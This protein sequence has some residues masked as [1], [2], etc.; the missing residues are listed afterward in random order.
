MDYRLPDTANLSFDTDLHLQAR[1][2]T[3]PE[4][5]MVR[6]T[7]DVLD[8]IFYRDISLFE[9]EVT[10]RVMG[11]FS[12]QT[13][14]YEAGLFDQIPALE[15]VQ[16]DLALRARD[17]FTIRN[18]I[19]RL[20]LD[21]Q[22]R[23]DVRIQDT[24]VEPHVTGDVDVTDGMVGFQGEEFQVRSGTL[25]FGGQPA[26]PYIDVVAGADIRNRCRE[27][28]LLEEFESDMTLAGELDETEEQY[29]HVLLNLQGQANNLDVQFESNPYADQR[30]IL[31]LLL[32]GCTVD[33]LSASSASGPTLE[34]ALGPLLG[35]IEREI[36][37]VVKVSEFTIMPGV[38]R[39]QVRIG[40]RLTRRLSWNFQLD[41]GM[42]ETAGGQRYQ[43]EYRLSDRWSAELSERSQNETNN[44]LLDAKLKYRLPLD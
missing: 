42:D 31:S 23:V 16:V 28:Q 14:R 6:G 27:G 4:T 7:F 40:D 15:D 35:R 34:I 26:N 13:E 39:T 38:E 10:G 5:W 21:L 11:A 22:L 19:D 32:T 41:T 8:G 37:D 44:F 36:Q 20:D 29:Y 12:R 24:L 2:V 1:D 18:Q 25:R 33:Q 43:L 30:D 9:Q 17:G 3:R